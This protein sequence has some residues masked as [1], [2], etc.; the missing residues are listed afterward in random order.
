M[1]RTGFE[2]FL[3]NGRLRSRA[4]RGYLRRYK[5]R[6]WTGGQRHKM[7]SPLKLNQEPLPFVERMP[8]WRMAVSPTASRKKL[9]SSSSNLSMMT[10][11]VACVYVSLYLR[12]R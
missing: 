7:T 2:A 5:K 6:M 9:A 1:K 8:A 10:E 4:E 3:M 11:A 12:W